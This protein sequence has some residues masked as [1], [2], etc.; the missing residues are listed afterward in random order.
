MDRMK[1]GREE[2]REEEKSSLIQGEAAPFADV[3]L[4]LLAGSQKK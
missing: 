4:R 3:L 2:E 1:D